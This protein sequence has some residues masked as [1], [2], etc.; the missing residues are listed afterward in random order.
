M[1]ARA[2][3]IDPLDLYVTAVILIGG[4]CMVW[5]GFDGADHPPLLRTPEVPI[6]ATF[7]LV[8]EL[9]PL[10]VFTR[11]AE[12]E[13]TTSTTFAMATMLAAGPRASFAAR[14]GATLLAGGFGRKPIKKV[15]F[16]ISQYAV[17]VAASGLVL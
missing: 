12:G 11:G 4:A 1:S 16:N 6:F 3:K 15:A 10:K 9:V 14:A 17:T 13:V 5:L 7:T 8:G 2:S